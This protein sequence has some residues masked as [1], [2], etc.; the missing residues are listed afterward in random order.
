MMELVLT[1]IFLTPN[2][3]SSESSFQLALDPWSSMFAFASPNFSKNPAKIVYPGSLILHIWEKFLIPNCP[4]VM[5]D[6]LNL[7]S[8]RILSDRFSQKPLWSL[9]FLLSNLPS[10]SPPPCS[11]GA[12]TCSCLLITDSTSILRSLFPSCNSPWIEPYFF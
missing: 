4:Q 1:T 6:H 9:M 3:G 5:S 7:L 8:A 12:P 2:S 11:L 10:S